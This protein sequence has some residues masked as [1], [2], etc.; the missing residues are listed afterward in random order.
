MVRFLSVFR[1]Q[2]PVELLDDVSVMIRMKHSYIEYYKSQKE[3]KYLPNHRYADEFK[4]G[5]R[6]AQY[7]VNC[8][9]IRE[10][11]AVNLSLGKKVR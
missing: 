2:L 6:S 8:L 7:G 11:L 5:L 4:S 9:Q 1:P 3:R 10:V